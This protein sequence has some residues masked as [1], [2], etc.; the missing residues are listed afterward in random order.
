M[1]QSASPVNLRILLP[2]QIF[3]QQN[4]VLRIIAETRAGSMGILPHRLDCV[5]ALVPGILL[6]ETK[7]AR[8]MCAAVDAGVLV[9]NGAEVLVSVRRAIAGTNLGELHEAVQREF[10]LID[11]REREVRSALQKMEAALIGR[12]A[13][14]KHG[15]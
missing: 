9:K 7:Q 2:F 12:F 5:A 6:F 11:A 8:T 1:M 3:A 10:L 4:E 15:R 13:E 14:F